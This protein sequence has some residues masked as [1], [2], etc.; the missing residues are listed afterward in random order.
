MPE[1]CPTLTF[2]MLFSLLESIWLQHSNEVIY[3]VHWGSLPAIVKNRVSKEVHRWYPIPFTILGCSCLSGLLSKKGLRGLVTCWQWLESLQ[4]VARSAGTR[5]QASGYNDKGCFQKRT[6]TS[7][8]Y[9]RLYQCRPALPSNCTS[10]KSWLDTGWL[11]VHQWS[12]TSHC[13]SQA[14]WKICHGRPT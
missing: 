10:C 11:P 7:D 8:G 13:W 12:N 1:I 2:A 3:R 14:Q 4:A 6:H 5:Y 9:W